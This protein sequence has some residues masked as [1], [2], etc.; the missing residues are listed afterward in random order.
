MYSCRIYPP[1]HR[2]NGTN[3]PHVLNVV[4]KP[5]KKCL[6]RFLAA[7]SYQTNSSVAYRILFGMCV[8]FFGFLSWTLKVHK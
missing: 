6:Y 8:L 2:K 4:E 7:P 3:G 1:I 5:M